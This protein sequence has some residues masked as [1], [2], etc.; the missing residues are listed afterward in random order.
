MTL[1]PGM[2]DINPR[3]KMSTDPKISL[4]EVSPFKI[5]LENF[6]I[7]LFFIKAFTI[8]CIRFGYTEEPIVI[9]TQCVIQ[10]VPCMIN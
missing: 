8:R 5:S 7:M 9:Q 1:K 2:A 4:F 6:C 10:K 3:F